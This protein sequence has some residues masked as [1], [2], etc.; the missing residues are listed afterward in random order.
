MV[1]WQWKDDGAL[2]LDSFE[3]GNK[4]EANR[5]AGVLLIVKMFPSIWDKL[6]LTHL[7]SMNVTSNFKALLEKGNCF[8]SFSKL[9]GVDVEC[10][11]TLLVF[12]LA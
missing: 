1:L 2:K 10:I 5:Q 7:K 4:N 12:L 9:I 8:D 3:T 6:N 11:Y